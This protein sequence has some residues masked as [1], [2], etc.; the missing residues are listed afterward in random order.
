MLWVFGFRAWGGGGGLGFHDL[1][2]REFGLRGLQGFHDP[3]TNSSLGIVIGGAIVPVS[4]W[5][6]ISSF[7]VEGLGFRV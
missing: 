4:I 7:R 3:Y 6:N 2:V 5:G 1:G